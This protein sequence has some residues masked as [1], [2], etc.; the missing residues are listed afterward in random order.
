MNSREQIEAMHKIQSYIDHHLRDVMTLQMISKIAGYSPSQTERLFKEV[1]GKN[2]FEYIRAMRLTDAAKSLRS[3]QNQRI[4]DI[5]LDYVFDSHE[6]FTRAFSKEFGISPKRY[7]QKPIP[8]PYFI[9]YDILGRYLFNNR[10]EVERMESKTVF[11]QVV[12]RPRRKAIIKRGIKATE[13]FQYCEE[14]GCDVWGIFESI[15]NAL[16]EP[17]GFWLPK[18]MIPEG[19]SEYV[20]GVEVPFNNQGVVP[21]GFDV[22]TLEPTL[23]MIFQG[24]PYKDEDFMEEIPIVQKHIE[25]F[26]P[27]L[28]GYA[29]DNKQPRFQ[30]NPLGY[31]G[32]IEA[33]P[34][35]KL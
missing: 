14:V 35:K 13:Y 20:Q 3:D 2:L 26:D 34:V 9:S 7:Q 32:Y 30:L 11:V 19:T 17:A 1:T 24:E 22:I 8:V 31:R 16:Y 33:K 5:S 23:M 27:K 25:S 28:Y 29:W 6:G 10:K 21:E 4:I 12:E 15:P 18:E